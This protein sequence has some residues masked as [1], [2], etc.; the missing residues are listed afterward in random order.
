MVYFKNKTLL[1]MWFV[2]K[3]KAAPYTNTLKIC[4]IHFN[5]FIINKYFKKNTLIIH[6]TTKY[7]GQVDRNF[8]IIKKRLL[9]SRKTIHV[10]CRKYYFALVSIR[11]E[12]RNNNL[13]GHYFAQFYFTFLFLIMFLLHF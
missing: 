4:L 3:I 5:I 8:W 1:F 12:S 6:I 9:G 11:L 2:L 7:T 10:C 13:V